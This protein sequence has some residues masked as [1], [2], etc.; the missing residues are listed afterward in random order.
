[1]A[2][3]K[4]CGRHLGLLEHTVDGVCMG[5]AEKARNEREALQVKQLLFFF[6]STPPQSGVMEEFTR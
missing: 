3:C 1:M 5:C 2:V 6:D 4:S